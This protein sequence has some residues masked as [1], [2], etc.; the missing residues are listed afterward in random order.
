MSTN[1]I[2]LERVINALGE[3]STD[4]MFVGGVVTSLLITDKLSPEVRQTKDVDCVVD[5][6]SLVDYR[7]IEKAL[8]DKGFKQQISDDVICRWHLDDLILDLLP[9]DE[10]IIGFSNPWYRDAIKHTLDI[11]LKSGNQIACISAPYFIATK[12]VAFNER[13][14]R[15]IYLSHDLEDIIAIIDG[16][17]TLINEI[18][19]SEEKLKNY[20]Q[21]ELVTLTIS[22]EF[23]SALPGMLGY[24]P[25]SNERA[26]LIWERLTKLTEN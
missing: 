13:G 8:R 12:F 15:D 14:N 22:D 20:L 10:N 4:L 16:R 21:K 1:L 25:Q 11:E 18:N 17:E 3:L 26:V 19:Q 2:M 24:G 6:V 7:K 9:T 23:K 5:V